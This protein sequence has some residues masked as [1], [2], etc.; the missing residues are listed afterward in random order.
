MAGG[1]AGRYAEFEAAGLF[2]GLD[3]DAADARYALLSRLADAGVSTPR[4]VRAAEHGRLAHLAMWQALERPGPRHTLEEIAAQSEIPLAD[5]ERWFRAMGRGVAGPSERVYGVD[6]LGLAQLLVKYRR[7]GLDETGLFASARILGRHLWAIADSVETLVDLRLRGPGDQ[8]ELATKLAAEVTHLAV[9]E[10]DILAHLVAN[11][12]ESSTLQESAE[13]HAAHG[14]L[15]VAFVDV[16]GFTSLG[17]MAGPA[18]LAELAEHFDRLT[19]E[20]VAPPVRFVKTVGDAVMLI[21]PDPNA[22]AHSVLR[23]FDAAAEA[24]LP[25]L[26]AGLAWGPALP[27]AGDWIGRTV[28]L[29]SRIATVATAGTILLDDAVHARLVDDLPR[30]PAGEYAL[31]GYEG[32]HR[33]YRLDPVG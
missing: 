31:K 13:S 25:P 26:H 18:E 21:S 7:L 24:G 8:T 1:G 19:T 14:E 3:A 28:N 17:E 6:D 10:S 4:L 9:M 16:V 11:R 12:L 27:Q 30:A 23:I 33:L 32:G 22:L 15:A 20:A 5:V 29:A 2:R